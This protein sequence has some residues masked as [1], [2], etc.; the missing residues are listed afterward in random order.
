MLVEILIAVVMNLSMYI[1][2]STISSA[3]AQQSQNYFKDQIEGLRQ[4]IVNST[5]Q[6]Q[7]NIMNQIKQNHNDVLSEIKESTQYLR[8]E[9]D[10]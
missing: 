3:Q 2:V 5:V 1:I 6:Q 7:G 8:K 9:S 10:I 4:T